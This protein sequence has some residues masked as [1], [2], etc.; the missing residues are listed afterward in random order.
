M[1]PQPVE[2]PTGEIFFGLVGALGTDLKSVSRILRES[3]L[4]QQ[5]GSIEV[6]L[7]DLLTGVES[8]R[9]VPSD[10]NDFRGKIPTDDVRLPED[11]RVKTLQDVGNLIRKMFNQGD[12][13]A[14]LAIARIRGIRVEKGRAEATDWI[15]STAFILRSLKNPKEALTL[16]RIYGRRF[17]L[18]AANSPREKRVEQLAQKIASTRDDPRWLEWKGKAEDL[19]RRDESEAGEVLGQ[20]VRDTFTLADVFVDTTNPNA[21]GLKAQIQRF[22][23]LVF[24]DPLHT[25]T[26]EE[27]GMFHAYAAASRSGALSR[28]VGAS[29]VTEDGSIISLGTNEVPKAGGGFYWPED[30][31]DARNLRK[32]FDQSDK[33]ERAIL[34]EIFERLEGQQW[35]TRPAEYTIDKLATIATRGFQDQLTKAKGNVA[36]ITA[37]EEGPAK[38]LIETVTKMPFDNKLKI[39]IL[40]AVDD[41]VK[42]KA[43]ADLYLISLLEVAFSPPMRGAMITELTEY[44]REV[45][46]EAAA[47]LEAARQGSSVSNC[48]LYSTTFPCHVCTRQIVAAGLKRLIYIE[49][50]PKSYAEEQHGDAIS[51]NKLDQGQKVNFVSFVGVAPRQYIPFFSMD[52]F[53][54]KRKDEDGN[55]SR[56]GPADTPSFREPPQSYL[57]RE[58]DLFDDTTKLIKANW[59]E[60][61]AGPNAETGMA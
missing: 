4:T 46:A 2:E 10:L 48:N 39:Q 44:S 14:R 41:I 1:D 25:P 16:R 17:F 42:K 43:S 19:A 5:F 60:P 59:S 58:I 30:Q 49:P 7:S 8:W 55:A 29:I 20:N 36:K 33:M 6:K 56:P 15:P 61:V 34:K 24:G 45:H 22:V 26:R 53:G 54:R 18:I 32:G 57:N 51:V 28:Q 21:G 52:L 11:E 9:N 47:L 3:L 35:L 50:Y 38:E 23:E 40:R 31:D 13:L 27:Y 37:G 12:A